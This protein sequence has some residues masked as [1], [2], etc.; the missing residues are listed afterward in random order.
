MTRRVDQTLKIL[1]VCETSQLCL[2]RAPLK[3]GIIVICAP[4]NGG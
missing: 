2:L 1:K 3:W 4:T